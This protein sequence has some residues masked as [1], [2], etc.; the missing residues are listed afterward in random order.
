MQLHNASVSQLN[1]IF[2]EDLER[3]VNYSASG[4]ENKFFTCTD[5]IETHVQITEC[6]L[7]LNTRKK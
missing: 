1:L 2:A 5:V 7:T 4:A 6:S 3:T